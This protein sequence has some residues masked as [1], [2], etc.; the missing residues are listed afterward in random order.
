[1]TTPSVQILEEDVAR[2]H[3]LDNIETIFEAKA[4]LVLVR[5]QEGIGKTTLLH[6]FA[7]RHSNLCIGIFIR[8]LSRFAYDENVI[9]HEIY[10]RA[11]ALLNRRHTIPES[12]ITTAHLQE[13]YSALQRRGRNKNIRYY[14]L[15]DGLDDVP[16]ADSESKKAILQMLPVG[17]P[18]FRFLITLEEYIGSRVIIKD[19]FVPSFSFDDTKQFLSSLTVTDSQ[20]KEI[21]STFKGIPGKLASLR[22]LSRG[23]V[24]LD[25]LLEDLPSRLPELFQ[26]EWQ[27]VEKAPQVIS[28]CLGILAFD[29]KNH[30]TQDLAS[31]TNGNQHDIESYLSNY[32]FISFEHSQRPTYI[33]EAFRRYA[34]QQLKDRQLHVNNILIDY[35]LKIPDSDDA[36]TYIPRHLQSAGRLDDLIDFL[37]PQH[38][39]TVI[40]RSSSL[41]VIKQKSELGVDTANQLRRDGDLFRFGVQLASCEVF[42]SVEAWREEVEAR[43]ALKDSEGAKQ[44]V[45]GIPL[46]EARFHLLAVIAKSQREVD[47]SIDVDITEQIDRL[48]Y[49]IDFSAIGEEAFDIA[50]DLVFSRPALA[51][52]IVEQA[53]KNKAERADSLDSA[54]VNLSY[55]AAC[56]QKPTEPNDKLAESFR[57]KISNPAAQRFSASAWLLLGQYSGAQLIAEVEKLKGASERLSLLR[58]WAKRNPK[59][60]DASDVIQHA[61]RLAISSPEV[62]V[63]ASVLKDL[64]KPLC[65]I[66]DLELRRTLIRMFETQRPIAQKVG[67]TDDYIGLWLILIRAQRELDET[68]A[69]IDLLDAYYQVTEIKELSTRAS[70]MALYV[71]ALSQIDPT[72]ELEKKDK[73]HTTAQLQLTKTIEDLLGAAAH[74]V[75]ATKNIIS[76]L[77]P[78]RIDLALGIIE[79]LNSE[80]RR[81]DSYLNLIQSICSQELTTDIVKNELAI[82]ERI[83][84]QN[85]RDEAVHE[86]LKAIFTEKN[87]WH[88]PEELIGKLVSLIDSIGTLSLRCR[89]GGLVSAWLSKNASPRFQSLIDHLARQ[90]VI[91]CSSIESG[92]QRVDT[93]FELSRVLAPSSKDLAQRFLNTSDAYRREVGFGSFDTVQ[94][95]TRCLKLAVRAFSGLLS[96][97]VDTSSDLVNLAEL[98]DRIPCR[99]T[100]ALV[101]ADIAFRFYAVHRTDDCARIVATKVRAML[102]DLLSTDPRTAYQTTVYCAPVL[103]FSQSLLTME[104]LKKLPRDIRDDAW[105]A[106]CYGIIRKQNPMESYDYGT[107]MPYEIPYDKILELIEILRHMEVDNSLARIISHISESMSSKK[108]KDTYTRPQRGEIVSKLDTIISEKL[109]NRNYITHEGWKILSKAEVARIKGA[110]EQ[111]W[112]EIIELARSVPN[113][114]DRSLVLALLASIV[115][116]SYRTDLLNEA[117]SVAQAIPI[118]L[119]RMIRLRAIAGE[120]SATEP[121][122][123]RKCLTDAMKLAT[124]SDHDDNYAANE[125]LQIIDMA[126]KMDP[127][128]ADKFADIT[129]TDPAHARARQELQAE[130]SILKLKKRIIEDEATFSNVS[131]NNKLNNYEDAIYRTLAALNADRVRPLDKNKARESVRFA[132]RRPLGEAFATI[133]LALESMVRK[134]RDTAEAGTYLRTVFDGLLRATDLASQAAI[135]ATGLIPFFSSTSQTDTAQSIN[136]KSGEKEKAFK[137]IEEWLRRDEPELVRICDPF[138]GPEDLEILLIIQ[139]ISPTCRVQILTSQKQQAHLGIDDRL[140]DCYRSHWRMKLCDLSPPETEIFVIGLQGD[141]SSPVHDRWLLSPNSGLRPG[142]SI[143]GLGSREAVISHLLPQ[144]VTARWAELERYFAKQVRTYMGQRV[145][146]TVFD[147]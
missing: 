121:A 135:R 18:S 67:P 3:L 42:A 138:F 94:M 39:S 5:G 102:D 142:T 113:I 21:Y 15:L 35:L 20:L 50:A 55:G 109:P 133:E 25:K 110:T 62:A 80:T 112:K 108:Y 74:H 83:I 51:I 91:W 41:V 26:L 98:I 29:R 115:H 44:L 136:V 127:S 7:E 70:C 78:Y 71:A 63:T 107:S 11:C 1:M 96:R 28:D 84:S 61:L 27:S 66:N 85:Q 48:F 10:E 24:N 64:A 116:K 40:K 93:G 52:Q 89:T 145:S 144:E 82:L 69:N 86:I 12:H 56:K 31:I 139:N 129:D 14:F 77:S 105:I 104:R 92:W 146:Y 46:R 59:S 90:L 72:L 49:E 111:E 76:A 128:L 95:Y 81:D 101:W 131:E 57:S 120:S 4:E 53:A 2:P 141:G 134:Y 22:R 137:F 88:P 143:N 47:S 65:H 8:A 32:S 30:S 126:Y 124:D 147:L 130:L 119:D 43:V 75:A 123:A 79:K 99:S 16:Q 118:F 45:Q 106:I 33:S 58:L 36:L 122:I 38:F 87:Q 140:I 100:R 37:S 13:V 68:A 73:L 117:C 103:Y 9:R 17:M 97:R 6:Q 19:F 60:V 132:A 34:K 23:S 114:S 125:R 54:L